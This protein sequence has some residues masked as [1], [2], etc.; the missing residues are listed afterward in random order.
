[1]GGNGWMTREKTDKLGESAARK[2]SKRKSGSVMVEFALMFT[3][4]MLIFVGTVDFARLFYTAVTTTDAARAGVGYGGLSNTAMGT[5]S[6]VVGGQCN[7][8][9][10]FTASIAGGIDNRACGNSAA[11]AGAHPN[12]AHGDFSAVGGG[13]MRSVSG[14]DDWAA[15]N[16]YE[17]N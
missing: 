11:V 5:D 4:L 12:E 13:R 2:H 15:G 7:E 16:L 10:G 8:A 9:N 6:C 17:D 3:L 14:E 1:M